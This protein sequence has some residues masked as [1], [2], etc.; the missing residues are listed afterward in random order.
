MCME[1]TN[2]SNAPEGG[3]GLVEI[4][5]SMFLL[6]LLAIAFLPLLIQSLQVSLTN[7]T[8]ATATQLVNKQMDLARVQGTT[9]GALTSFAA[10]APS[11]VPDARGA[12]QPYRSV[13]SCPASYPGTVTVTTWVTRSGQS[14]RLA[15][16]VTLILVKSAT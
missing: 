7:A 16:A 2:E 14:I 3:F 8:T 10:V 12:L 11:V 4:V 1:A 13:G 5:V 6:S 9:C 15:E